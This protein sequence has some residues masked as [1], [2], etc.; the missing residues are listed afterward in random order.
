MSL[1]IFNPTAGS[2][3]LSLDELWAEAE[4]LG[5]IEVDHPC[6]DKDYRVE[7]TFYRGGDISTG[8]Q[9]RARGVARN[10]WDAMAAA[11]T[12]ARELK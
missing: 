1:T 2:V 8:S 12:E 4:K 7:I 6:F 9:V 11:I 10:I 3:R 5:K